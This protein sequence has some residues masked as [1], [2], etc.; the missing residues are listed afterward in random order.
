MEKSLE[1]FKHIERISRQTRR[2]QAYLNQ[3]CDQNLRIK[4]DNLDKERELTIKRSASCRRIEEERQQLVKVTIQQIAKERQQL[5]QRNK[6]EIEQ[7]TIQKLSTD[8]KRRP[9]SSIKLPAIGTSCR[10]FSHDCQLYPCQ[11]VYQYTSF[12]GRHRDKTL[13]K[14]NSSTENSTKSSNTAAHLKEF[15]KTVG[16]KKHQ[17]SSRQ[18]AL[19]IQNQNHLVH[20]HISLQRTKTRLDEQSRLLY[21]QLTQKKILGY[22]K[23][24]QQKLSQAIE[25][26]LKVTAKFCA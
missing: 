10:L 11:P 18:L 4:L 3:I 19:A 25:S 1:Q 15:L 14:R 7:K 16:E 23:E 21:E 2:H 13:Q 24:R 22:D 5:L 6:T 26:H 9:S 17:H 20:R 8:N 12:L